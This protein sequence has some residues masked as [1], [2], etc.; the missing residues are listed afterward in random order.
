MRLAWQQPGCCH[1]QCCCLQCT[2]LSA[3][4]VT[5]HLV[6]STQMAWQTTTH[7]VLHVGWLVL[8]LDAF[9]VSTRPTSCCSLGDCLGH[10]LCLAIA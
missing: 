3:H 10:G 6:T 1:P 7:T 2:L 9:P 4:K 8:R 5:L